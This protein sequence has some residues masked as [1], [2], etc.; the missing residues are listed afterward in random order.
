VAAR[1]QA[2]AEPGGVTISANVLEQVEGKHDARFEDAGAH[3]VKN[4]A[5][6]ISVWRW[7]P[8][9]AEFVSAA[10]GSSSVPPL[11]DKPSIAVLPF[12]NMSGDPEQ[13]YFS[14]GISE[15]LITELSKIP[16]LFVIARHS[17]FAYKGQAADMQQISSDLGV[18]YLL[19]GSVRRAG[20]RVRINAQ[21]IDAVT[22]GHVWAERYDRDLDD[23]FALQDDVIRKIIQVLTEKVGPRDLDI[24]KRDRP[25]NLE[26]YDLVL[27]GRELYHRY[28][29]EDINQAKK[30]LKRA[31]E[32]DP[33][34]AQSYIWLG[35]CHWIDWQNDWSTSGFD[36][37][38]SCYD[39]AINAVRL[40]PKEPFAHLILGVAHFFRRERVQAL[41][42]YQEALGLQSDQPDVLVHYSELLTC[43]GHPLEG[44]HLIRK[45]MRLNPHYPGFY[46]WFLGLAQYAARQYEDAVMTLKQAPQLGVGRRILAASLGQLGRVEEARAEALE[47]LK[48]NPNFS[49]QYWASTEPFLNETDC[50]HF[51]EGYLKAG[52]PE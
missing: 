48:D 11:P 34:Y 22:G 52:L 23:I 32:L 33:N 49:T 5:R 27:H 19:E 15:D 3:E 10:I 47:F 8:G 46:S 44:I 18:R 4:I 35:F 6:P 30:V 37:I 42:E 26:T 43:D 45:A 20:T 29:A 21:L 2:L 24:A 14:D 40:D 25:A 36:L 41:K 7:A 51:V 16:G 1:L 28:T 31:T 50:Q 17:S 12:N 38:D 39:A 13:G 9:A